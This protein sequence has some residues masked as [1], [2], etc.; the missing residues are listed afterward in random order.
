MR[1]KYKRGT[2][3]KS[4][5]RKANKTFFLFEKSEFEKKRGEKKQ[6]FNRGAILKPVLA[7]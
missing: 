7:F 5:G 1:R 4:R 3:E 2:R 6:I